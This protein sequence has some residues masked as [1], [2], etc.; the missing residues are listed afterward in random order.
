MYTG[1]YSIYYL[2]SLQNFTFLL[3]EVPN[4]DTFKSYVLF[5]RFVFPHINARL[6]P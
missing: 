2:I 3:C 1:L 5:R 6:N 4:V